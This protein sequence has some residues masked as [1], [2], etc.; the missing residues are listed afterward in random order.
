MSD[1]LMQTEQKKL[2]SEQLEAFYHTG[3]V[4]DQVKHFLK[5]VPPTMLEREKVIVD[6]GGGCGFFASALQKVIDQNVRVIDSDQSSIKACLA[7]GVDAVLGDALTPQYQGDENVVCFNLILHHLVGI[8]E[9]ETLNLQQRA[10]TTWINHAKAFF[11]HEY[12]YDSYLNYASGRLIYNITN[13][14]T[15]SSIASMISKFIPSLRANTFGVGVRF[16]AHKEWLELFEKLDLRVVSTVR[17]A[18]EHVS[19]PRRL[20]LIRSCRRDS[21]VLVAATKKC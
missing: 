12:I 10:L 19:F 7:N 17:G 6:I 13:S 14:R 18:D 5:L 4:E 9:Q 8:N 20:L 11:V 15:L 1:L 16:R 21:F 3:F 2:N